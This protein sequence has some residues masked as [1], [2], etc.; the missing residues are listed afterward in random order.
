MMPE[1]T[2]KQNTM[3]NSKRHKTP[4]IMQME[5][6]ECGAASL[7]MILGYHGKWVPLEELRLRCGVS[8]DG[9]KASNLLKAARSY[10]LTSKGFN[11][12]PENLRTMSL[13]MV[14]FWNFNHYLV[15]EGFRNGKVYLNDPAAGKRVVSDEEF[16]LS[17]TG[18]ALTFEL[19]AE[20]KKGGQ[21]QSVLAALKRRF[22]G[23]NDA[24]AYLVLVGVALVLPGL[25]VPV[26]SSV[27]IDKLLISGM[28]SWLKPLLLGIVITALLRVALTWLESYYLLRV[29]TQIALASASKFF[30]HVLR[31]PVE[32]YTQRSPGEISSRVGINDKV[33]GML[34]GD[35]AKAFL[36]VIQAVFFAALMFFYDVWL[37]LISIV[38]VS[39]N[40][41]VMQQIS[42]KTKEASQKLAI[43]GG[44][45][46]GATM[47]GLR[48]METVKSSGGE[49]SFFSKWAGYQAKYVNS[50][51]AMARVGLVM[52]SLPALLTVLNGLLILGVGGM[53]VID[54][55][56]SIGM[57]VAFQSLAA[58]FTGPVQSLVGLGKK[59]LEV[60][61]DMNRLDDVMQYRE[62]PW[63]NRGPLPQTKGG[64]VAAKL[65]GKVELNNISFGYNPAGSAL[66]EN[67][68]LV[69]NP[70]ERVAIVG[71][72]GCGKSTISR[73]VMGLYEPWGGSIKFDDQPRETF[74][75]YEFFNSV[76]LV[77]QDIVLFEG[78]IRDN[79]S[80]W[81]KSVSDQDVI[82]AAKD[83]C[84]HDV[85]MSRPGGYDSKLEENGVN[86]S[87]GQR[88]RLE[89]ARALAT[90]P[91]ILVMDEGTS[92][93]D[94]ATEQQIDENLRRRGC[95]CIII[96]H[97]L[98]TIRDADEI[99]VLSYGHIVE[100]GTHDN[101]IQIDGGFYSRLIAQH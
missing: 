89:I 52:G 3:A 78:S 15:V 72:S 99:V 14:V 68:N 24:I 44:K 20:F 9:S 1:Q 88:Q 60:Q 43:D 79:L 4:T 31:L 29:R 101:L 2:K 65:A 26:F 100:R 35:L 5:A 16:D 75:R 27:F 7:A 86:M 69:L 90:N 95:A 48:V 40:V 10:G 93:L 96:A 84:I 57:L 56:L 17:F 25:V 98:S 61:G 34:S 8:R 19:G 28:D 12:E 22:V 63:L 30:W 32:F 82:Q 18:V 51:Q 77:D 23:L 94:P 66:V 80:M 39:I 13:P 11:K 62:D 71:P 6:V 83:A 21:P 38:V 67:F 92:A 74:G 49:S 64:Q 33:A 70:G 85:I 41:F 91:R 37:T 36:A 54:G 42:Q 58:S 55:H 73:L 50:E 53:R 46:F 97:R 87:G 81:D 45:V 59:M 47:S 76:A